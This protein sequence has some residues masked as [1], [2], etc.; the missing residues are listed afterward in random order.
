MKKEAKIT[1]LI[2]LSFVLSTLILSQCIKQKTSDRYV[3]VAK[4][5]IPKTVMVYIAVKYTN[6]DGKE[7]KGMYLGS[8]VF[9]SP[10]GHVL[11]AAHLFNNKEITGIT[12]KCFNDYAYGATLLYKDNFRD[13]ALLKIEDDENKTSYVRLADPRKLAI[14]QE[15]VAIGN[16]LGFEWSVSHGI[17]SALYR[18]L[19]FLYNMVQTDTMI[20][21][22]NSGGPLLNLKGELVGINSC[23]TPVFRILPVNT[24]IGFSVSSGQIIEFLSLFGKA[25]VS[26]PKFHMDYWNFWRKK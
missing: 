2:V 5:S 17:I 20:N 11:T 15:V 22:G 21:P 18:D 23:F 6:L 7:L 9:V 14:G 1:L 10:N 25:D 16:P 26:I 19:G 8:G 13:L 12:V 3:N 24:G 4:Q